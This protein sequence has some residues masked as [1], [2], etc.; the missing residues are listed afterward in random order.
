MAAAHSSSG[1]LCKH[2]GAASL[3][4][5]RVCVVVSVTAFLLLAVVAA[6]VLAVAAARP[7]PADATVTALRLASLS[8]SPGGSVNA[9]LDAV[10]AIRNPSPVASFAH[11]AGRAEVYYRGALAADAGV[12][13]GRVAARGS[14][15]LSVRLTVL[16]DRLA[17]HAPQLYGDV[18]GSGDVPLTVRTTVPGTVTVLGVLR[19]RVVVLTA[20]DVALSV[21]RPG[22][23][24][25]SCRILTK[26]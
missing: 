21:R 22:A 25:S 9:T 20:R 12:P 5:L 14:D 1:T 11:A 10:L 7:R 3:R 2:H 26:L 24:S 19:H 4:R 17:G 16:A 6:A 13:P 15:S 18:V 8:V 23:H